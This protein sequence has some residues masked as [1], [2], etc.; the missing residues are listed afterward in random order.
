VPRPASLYY[1]TWFGPDGRLHW[2]VPTWDYVYDAGEKPWKPSPFVGP[3]EQDPKPVGTE[4]IEEGE[5]RTAQDMEP[6]AGWPFE[7]G[8]E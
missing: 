8:R 2:I 6:A 4:A 3:V 7:A 1:L 5:L